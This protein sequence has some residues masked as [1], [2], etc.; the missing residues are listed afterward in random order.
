[1]N[2]TYYGPPKRPPLAAA[3]KDIDNAASKKPKKAKKECA[4]RR[5]TRLAPQ[6][7]VVMQKLFE[8]GVMKDHEDLEGL[9][10]S[11]DHL[12]EVS[13]YI[14]SHTFSVA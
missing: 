5:A 7:N 10:I 12:E 8:R 4:S 6:A 13:N 14:V 11:L 1:M 3:R 2:E 9:R